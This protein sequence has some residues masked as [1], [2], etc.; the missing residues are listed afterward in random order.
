M[1]SAT[2]PGGLLRWALAAP[3]WLFRLHL[4]W[5]LGHRFLL[6]THRGRRSGRVYQ[7]MLEV[8]S[9]DPATRESVVLSGWGEHADWYRNLQA[10]PALAVETGGRRYVPAQRFLT[11]EEVYR[12]MQGYVRRNRWAAGT[13]HRLLGLRFDGSESD[14][15]HMSALRGVAFRPS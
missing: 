1:I 6:L 7:T 15:A 2:R 10:A 12:A 5:L 8:V 13:V 14:R 9:F 11:P 3:R 4:G